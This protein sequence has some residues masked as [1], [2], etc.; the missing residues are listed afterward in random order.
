MQTFY[1]DLAA[2]TD[3]QDP[4]RRWLEHVRKSSIKQIGVLQEGVL[5]WSTW[6]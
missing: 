2:V 4:S 3:G 5:A 1:D 6:N